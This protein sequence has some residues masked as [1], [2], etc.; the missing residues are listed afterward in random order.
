MA[1]LQHI[2]ALTLRFFGLD[3]TFVWTRYD[4]VLDSILRPF[5]RDMTFVLKKDV[6]NFGLDSTSV[7]T[8]YDVA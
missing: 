2:T 8:R 3:S 6:D 4:V 5:G 7:W 1:A